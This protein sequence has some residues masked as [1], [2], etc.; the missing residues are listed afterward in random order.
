VQLLGERVKPVY[1]TTPNYVH[2]LY[3]LSF[4]QACLCVFLGSLHIHINW[5]LSA[6]VTSGGSNPAMQGKTCFKISA[7]D[8]PIMR[9]V[10]VHYKQKGKGRASTSFSTP[11]SAACS[12]SSFSCWLFPLLRCRMQ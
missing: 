8:W 10:I 4:M 3:G 12:S 2:G 1:H 9:T 7:S 6:D 11:S 5:D